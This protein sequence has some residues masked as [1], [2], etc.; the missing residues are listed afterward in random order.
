MN[1][2]GFKF[3]VKKLQLACG[4]IK[5]L[6]YEIEPGK[7]VRPGEAKCQTIA[8]WPVPD[9]LSKIRQFLGLCG[10]FRRTIKNFASIANPLNKLMRKDSGYQK[11]PLPPAGVQAFNQLKTQL[12]S[13]PTLRPVD[14]S[15]EFILTCDASTTAVGAVLTQRGPQGVEHAC[16]YYSRSLNEAERR[17]PPYYLEHL[18]MVSACRHF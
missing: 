10:F 13:R 2:N 7:A 8:N 5:Y 14:F 3:S 11:G 18:A 6:G 17:R 15:Q 12:M 4:K 1:K 16:A 9:D